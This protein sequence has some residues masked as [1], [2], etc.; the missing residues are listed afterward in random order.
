MRTPPS[1]PPPAP[2]SRP[3]T[4]RQG[5]QAQLGARRRDL[6]TTRVR[7]ISRAVAI[8]AAAAAAVLGLV[9]SKQ[10]PGHGHRL[11]S[12]TD[13][14]GTAPRR[15]RR[16]ALDDCASTIVVCRRLDRYD[17]TTNGP[18]DTA[19]SSTTKSATVVSGG[20]GRH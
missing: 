11:S 2:S 3:A 4:G 12:T 19:P 5:R 1:R 10:I 6:A 15:A 13:D 8:V 14:V 17:H 18:G 9:V 20:T 16:G 7:R